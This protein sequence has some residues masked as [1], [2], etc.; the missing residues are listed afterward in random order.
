MAFEGKEGMQRLPL[1][2]GVAA[3][4]GV[5][6]RTVPPT[7]VGRRGTLPRRGADSLSDLQRGSQSAKEICQQA[8]SP[9]LT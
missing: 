9:E 6:G 5:S 2:E 4:S 1:R 8:A 3:E 7:S